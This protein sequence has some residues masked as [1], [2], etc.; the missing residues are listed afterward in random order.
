VGAD[1]G[2][3][4][5]RSLTAFWLPVLL[6]GLAATATAQS[7][8]YSNITE[9]LVPTANRYPFTSG[10]T[11]GPDGAL[12][13]TEP[14]ANNIG[15]ITTTGVVTAYPIPAVDSQPHWI[16]VGPDGALWFTESSPSGNSIGRI[17]TAG[18]ITEYALP[19]ANSGPFGITLGSDG[20]LWFTEF[21]GN[22]IGRITTTGVIAEY[23]VPAGSGANGI[24]AGPDGALWF[25]EY[26]GNNIGR[27]TNTG[28][29]T[30]YPV[31]T[32][33]SEP[34]AIAGGPDGAMWFAEANE[35]KIGRITTAG[36]ITEYIVSCCANGIAAGPDGA[37][38]FVTTSNIGRITTTFVIT[39]YPF[40]ASNPADSQPYGIAAG[41]DGALWFTEYNGNEVGRSPACGLGFSASFASTTLTMHFN[42]GI[43]TPAT[44]NILL[45]DTTGTQR[46]FSRAIPAVVPP[47]AFTL[48][49]G[50][51]PNLGTVTVIPGLSSA[52]GQ[53][54]C[55]EWAT[56]NTAQ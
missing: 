18:V 15:R 29:I 35:G 26:Y 13:F 49:W 55:A 25:T 7:G 3:L 50:S 12:W 22:R 20:A 24:A 42:L 41:P 37:L 6:L 51:F 46:P 43:D 27:I 4:Y 48:T 23:A 39:Q 47:Q 44:F 10:I 9:Y 28:V 5:Q 38:W 56:V 21:D 1:T 34:Q 2:N 17:T 36:A 40:P 30:Y 31:P 19:N 45:E 54:I 14:A 33:N 8:T 53:P 11:A 16:T 52:P 32:D